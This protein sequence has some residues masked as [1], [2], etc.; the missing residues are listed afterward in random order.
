[1]LSHK[2]NLRKFITKIFRKEHKWKK[3]LKAMGKKEEKKKK[4]KKEKKK[5]MGRVDM[6]I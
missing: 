2:Q 6:F 5:A 3:K 1:M 4:K